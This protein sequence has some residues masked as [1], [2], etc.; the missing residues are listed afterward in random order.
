MKHRRLVYIMSAVLAMFI[1][2]PRTALAEEDTPADAPYQETMD[3]TVDTT[4]EP[5]DAIPD[6]ATPTLPSVHN[7][8]M[9]PSEPTLDPVVSTKDSREVVEMTASSETTQTTAVVV[10]KHRVSPAAITASLTMRSIQNSP[11]WSK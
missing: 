11:I 9:T 10:S 3:M 8:P 6:E 1:I 7:S 5:A 2:A 4:V